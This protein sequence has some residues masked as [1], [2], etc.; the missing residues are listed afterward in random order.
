[1]GHIRPIERDRTYRIA[2]LIERPAVPLSRREAAMALCPIRLTGPTVSRVASKPP[3]SLSF[4]LSSS[5]TFF[6]RRST[7][8]IG[9]RTPARTADGKRDTLSQQPME[10]TDRAGE[11]FNQSKE[12]EGRD[13]G[14]ETGPRIGSL[15]GQ[16]EFNRV[17][18][19]GAR[20]VAGHLRF[21]CGVASR[22]RP[23]DSRRVNT[24]SC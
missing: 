19:R 20:G 17:D 15:A 7:G 14:S 18:R 21:L 4:Q 23:W 6:L 16:S 11:D 8:R 3:R 5:Q 13:Q 24:R 10:C 1:M 22:D 2:W 12:V 9:K